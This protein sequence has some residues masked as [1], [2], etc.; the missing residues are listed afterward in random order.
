MTLPRAALLGSIASL[1]LLACA[2]TMVPVKSLS[3]AAPAGTVDGRAAFLKAHLKDGSL[4]VMDTNAWQ[5]DTLNRSVRGRGRR[6]DVNRQ[7]VDSGELAAS[8]DSIALYET[9]AVRQHRMVTAMSVVSG[10][11]AV[12]TVSCLANPKACFGSCP[13]FYVTDGSGDVLQ[14]EGFSAS[15][16]PALEATDL[17]ALY[18][19]RPRSQTLDIRMTNEALETHVVRRVHLL[20]IRRSASG[21]VFATQ[22]GR[23]WSADTIIA[24]TACAA[25]EGDC[26]PAL[27]DADAVE[28]F[29][30][31]DS[32]DLASRE[33]IDLVF[34]RL[35]GTVGLVIG[36]RQTLLTTYVLYQALAYLGPSASAFLASLAT[37]A[38]ARQHA[39]SL[40]RLLGGIDVQLPDSARAWRTVGTLAETGPLATDVKV[41]PLPSTA[42][43]GDSVRVRLSLTRGLWRLDHVALA[44][45]NSAG[46]PLRLKPVTVRRH[47]REDRAALSAL[48]DSAEPLVTLPGDEYTISFELPADFSEYE[49]FLESRGYYLE[50]MREE[51]MREANPV[52]AAMLATDPA[53]SLRLMAPEFKKLEPSME[54]M[55]WNSRYVRP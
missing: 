55:F 32:T 33:T 49:L 41:V 53:A 5:L 17:D 29:S 47:G 10:V 7:A 48:R 54:Q 26:L 1:A 21:R 34:P 6:F 24:P 38:D 39:G 12:V 3:D 27:R 19:A 28:R 9:N 35:E 2:T 42:A 45:L 11:S 51:W 25:S 40:G 50:W 18:R 36:A 37:S 31:T 43:D 14:A 44:S 15:I 20:A 8:M 30:A 13:T 23:F 4:L 22:S 52:R 46:E 16:A